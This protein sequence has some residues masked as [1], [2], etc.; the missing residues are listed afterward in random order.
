MHFFKESFEL[1]DVSKIPRNHKDVIFAVW[2]LE[3]LNCAGKNFP[4]LVTDLEFLVIL[5]LEVLD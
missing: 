2:F 4:E 3:K 1:I 5:L